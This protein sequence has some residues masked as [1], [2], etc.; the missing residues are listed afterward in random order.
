M[1]RFLF[2]LFL[3]FLS[4][5]FLSAQVNTDLPRGYSPQEKIQL[6]APRLAPPALSNGITEPPALPVRAMGEWEELQAV[7]ITWNAS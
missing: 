5:A 7:L 2:T 4:A 6:L 3:L 1:T